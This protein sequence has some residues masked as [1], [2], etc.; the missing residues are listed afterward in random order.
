MLSESLQFAVC[1]ALWV[2]RSAIKLTSAK[3]IR[4]M[5]SLFR[6]VV[7]SERLDAT[8]SRSRSAAKRCSAKER[9]MLMRLEAGVVGRDILWN[10]IYHLSENS[11]SSNGSVITP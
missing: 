2:A 8:I 11:T 6:K 3:A 1:N 10:V 7:T 9:M 4:P 5:K